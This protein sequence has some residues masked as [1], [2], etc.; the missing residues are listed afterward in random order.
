[1]VARQALSRP[2]PPEGADVMAVT[3]T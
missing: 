2:F 3:S 1:M